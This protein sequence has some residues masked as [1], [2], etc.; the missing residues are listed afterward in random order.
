MSFSMHPQERSFARYIRLGMSYASNVEPSTSVL[1]LLSH[2]NTIDDAIL[3][4]DDILDESKVRNGKPCLYLQEGIPK[5]LV[6]AELLKASADEALEKIMVNIKTSSR[7]KATVHYTM[8][9]LLQDIYKGEK[10]SFEPVDSNKDFSIHIKN[11]LEMIT[12]F[13]GGHIKYGL[14]IGQLIMNR[15]PDENLDK[16]AE[17]TGVIRQI[18][19]DF[20]DYFGEHHEPFGDFLGQ[21]WRLPEI[22]FHKY[23]GDRLHIRELLE[24]EQ[25]VEARRIILSP[26][27]RYELYR[28][29]EMAYK[30]I[31]AINLDISSL[32]LIDFEQI[33][34]RK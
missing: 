26:Q 25:Y 31:K 1:T 28:Y 4:V 11:Y 19:D 33:L 9:R 32:L 27:V 29:C 17:A 16:I 20:Q 18:L 6:T 13:T 34:T 7:F 12:L 22:L 2:V 14:Q 21:A 30:K 8:F 15:S 3:I 23:G 24:A 10:I 5:A